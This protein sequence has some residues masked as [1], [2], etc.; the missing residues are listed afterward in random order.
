MGKSNDLGGFRDIFAK[1]AAPGVMTAACILTMGADV[2]KYVALG[3]MFGKAVRLL[4]EKDVSSIPNCVGWIQAVNFV[5]LD[6][7]MMEISSLAMTANVVAATAVPK[8]VFGRAIAA[9]MAA[10]VVNTTVIGYA[11]VE[12]LKDVQKKCAQGEQ[13]ERYGIMCPKVNLEPPK[14]KAPQS[15]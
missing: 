14:Q 11:Q 13:I 15:P 3:F 4:K 8:K 2:G 1:N 10:F 5:T 7:N 9:S 6:Q 12:D